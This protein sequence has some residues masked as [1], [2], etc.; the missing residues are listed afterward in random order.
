MMHAPWTHCE[1]ANS[2]SCRAGVWVALCHSPF[3][4][5][6]QLT[7]KIIP[8]SPAIAGLGLIRSPC[9]TIENLA[10]ALA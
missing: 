4:H 2:S 8:H 7:L 3:M 9:K 1:A 5:A 10:R 6:L